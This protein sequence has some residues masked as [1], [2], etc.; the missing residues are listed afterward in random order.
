MY[1]LSEC[2]HTVAE[3]PDKYLLPLLKKRAPD[4]T[5]IEWKHNSV[6]L[7]KRK[8]KIIKPG[9]QEDIT[10]KGALVLRQLAAKH[11]GTYV[12][13]VFQDGKS[14]EK[15]EIELCVKGE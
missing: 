12:G 9:K 3:G 6:L 5:E 2:T 15:Q 13:E 7:F 8:N 10:D 4:L 1:F 14:V 11:A